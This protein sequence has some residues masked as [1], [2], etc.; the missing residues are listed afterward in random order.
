MDTGGRLWAV[1]VHAA[2]EADGQASLPLVSDILWYSERV[3]KVIGDSAYGGVFAKELA[4]WG[5]EFERAS[6][7]ESSHGFVPI[8]KR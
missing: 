2:N 4:Y 8:A 3:K 5:F 6:R 7:P 1:H